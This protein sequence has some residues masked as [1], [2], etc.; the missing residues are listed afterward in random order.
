LHKLSREYWNL[1]I[2]K[3]KNKCIKYRFLRQIFS[4]KRVYTAF[5][6]MEALYMLRKNFGNKLHLW[7][8][9][10]ELASVHN[11]RESNLNLRILPIPVLRSSKSY[12]QAI[13]S[14]QEYYN[15]SYVGEA[16]AEKGFHFLPSLVT[17]V[18]NS[19]QGFKVVFHIQCSSSQRDPK[20]QSTTHK[21]EKL[22]KRYPKQIYLYMHL[23]DEKEYAALVLCSDILLILYDNRS[24]KLRSSQVY[25]EGLLRGAVPLVIKGTS[26][27]NSLGGQS[28]WICEC[29]D[30]AYG[31]LIQI[32]EDFEEQGKEPQRIGKEMASFHTAE[33]L[34]FSLLK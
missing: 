3:L 26:M 25:I 19:D 29:P 30:K 9:T 20:I 22:Q 13:R 34:V 31:N 2:K 7:T 16:R 4:K 11:D 14:T 18:L 10:V 32:L 33:N 15:I 23:L 8:D 5:D 28:K 17:A 27:A 24:Y 1:K 6:R 21:L 12:T